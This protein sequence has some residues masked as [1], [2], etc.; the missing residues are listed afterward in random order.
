M[1]EQCS[2]LFNRTSTANFMQHQQLM[3]EIGLWSTGGMTV[4]KKT[5]A[6]TKEPFPV[7]LTTTDYTKKSP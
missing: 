3:T 1:L 4:T 6:L 2:V 7:P 5:K